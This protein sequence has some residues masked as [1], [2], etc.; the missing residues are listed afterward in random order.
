[1]AKFRLNK[2]VESA[3]GKIGNMVFKQVGGTTLFTSTPE[4]KGEATEKQVA[5]RE[6]FK[7]AVAYA[8]ASLADPAT[9]AAYALSVQGEDFQ[10]AFTAAV[11]DYLNSPKVDSLDVS[12]YTGKVGESLIAKVYDTFKVTNVVITITQA[13]GTIL[14]SGAATLEKGSVN[15]SYVTTKAL[16]AMAGARI[17]VVV[18]DNPGN[19]STSE[20]ML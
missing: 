14:E 13:D 18:T 19:T 17:K 7:R 20:Y 3:S 10:N 5:H 12:G 8:K 16:A 1:M 2:M 4:F 11:T 6:R 9:K 15:W